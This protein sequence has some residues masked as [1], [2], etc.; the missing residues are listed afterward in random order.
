VK[1]G[2]YGFGKWFLELVLI[3]LAL[4]FLYPLYLT[5]INGM[6]PYDE[7]AKSFLSFPHAIDFQN[8]TNV[9]EQ[10]NYTRSFINSLIITVF[11]VCGILLISSAAAYQLVRQPGWVSKIIFFA[12][13]PW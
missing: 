3:L 13:H 2:Y 9:W 4:L 10:L 12:Y 7:M 1:E 11:S 5:V 8:F 6:K